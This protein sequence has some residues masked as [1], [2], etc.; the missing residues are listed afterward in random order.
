[1]ASNFKD[2]APTLKLP[3]PRNS[4]IKRGAGQDESPSRKG[5]LSPKK[6][7]SDK[8]PSVGL[9]RAGSIISVDQVYKAT[10]GLNIR[11]PRMK[12]AIKNLGLKGSDL[13]NR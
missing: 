12:Q 4:P 13:I 1:M 11:S 5:S 3:S 10:G 6:F 8:S 2:L 9:N 7:A